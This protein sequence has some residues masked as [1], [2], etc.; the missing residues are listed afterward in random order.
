MSAQTLHRASDI[1]MNQACNFVH[2]KIFSTSEAHVKNSE[3][4]V[5]ARYYKSKKQVKKYFERPPVKHWGKVEFTS[6]SSSS[7]SSGKFSS[8][9]STEVVLAVACIERRRLSFLSL[10]SCNLDSAALCFLNR[11]TYIISPRFR[12]LSTWRIHK[13]WCPVLIIK[14]SQDHRPQSKLHRF[15][16]AAIHDK[17]P[18]TMLEGLDMYY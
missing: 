4:N 9:C 14:S 13:N 5:Y 10:I 6:R 2:T 12:A 16:C 7:S 3:C 8:P 1:C 15:K 18:C 17:L 11:A